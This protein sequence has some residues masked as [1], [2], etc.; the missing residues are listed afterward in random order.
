MA[1]T[2]ASKRTAR[3]G[4]SRIAT[5]RMRR[6]RFHACA[7]AAV[8]LACGATSA[9]AVTVCSASD[10]TQNDPGCPPGAGACTITRV[11]DVG[12]G[13]VLDF[14]GRPVTVAGSATLNVGTVFG[15]RGASVAFA[16]GSL[17]DG[18]ADAAGGH[19]SVVIV[20]SPGPVAV[21]GIGTARAR[22]DVS[23]GGTAGAVAIEAGG[24]VTIAGRMLSD[25]TTAAA[26]GG[27]IGVASDATVSVTSSA[28][29]SATGGP[30]GTGGTVSLS[31]GGGVDVLAGIDVTGGDGG[32]VAVDAGGDVAVAR[33]LANAT[34]DIGNG[35]TV[36]VRGAG[37]VALSDIVRANGSP[38]NDG[39]LGGDGGTITA[40]ALGGDLT[41]TGALAA[42]AAAPDGTGG[43]MS[44]VAAGLVTSHTAAPLS[45]R[46]N[47]GDSSGGEATVTAGSDAQLGANVDA[48]GGDDGGSIEVTAGGDAI[49]GGRLDASARD[50]G[51]FG[52]AVNIVAGT[53]SAGEITLANSVDAS[54]GG[55]SVA[56]GCGSAGTVDLGGCDVTVTAT[57]QVLARADWAGFITGVARELLT[58][59]GPMNASRTTGSGTDGLVDLSHPTRRPPQ[60]AAGKVTPPAP[61]TGLPTCSAGGETGCL[62]PCV[63]CGP[64]GAGCC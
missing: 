58:V 5:A 42:E 24:P 56:D 19:G 3:E 21:Q 46:G 47:G 7:F 60:I 25:R 32:V 64:P 28:E 2:N 49:A 6:G 51:G 8:A 57:A 63:T 38:A 53:E 50:A 27:T 14:T 23:A 62:V 61:P 22:I 15:L 48:S 1:N 9:D 20:Q 36:T 55:C 37:D 44:L 39:F 10:V 34:G 31:A 4:C 29:I 54:G 26:N 52:G 16:P 17:V 13:C 18:R 41:V 45:V 43:T 11:F 59:L 12:D 40:E 30:D 35:G 33:I